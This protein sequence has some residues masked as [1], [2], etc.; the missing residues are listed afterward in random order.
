MGDG[1]DELDRLDAMG[2]AAAI[3]DGEVREAEVLDRSLARIAERDPAIEA[4]TEVCGEIQPAHDGPLRGVPFV[5]KDL[6]L[7]HLARPDG[8]GHPDG[9]EV[10]ELIETVVHRPPRPAN[11]SD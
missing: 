2:L 7:A 1:F 8:G 9:I 11:H 6:G 10:V 4:V 5:V 3:R